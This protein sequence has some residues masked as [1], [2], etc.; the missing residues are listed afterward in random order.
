LLEM[1]VRGSACW[2]P[3]CGQATRTVSCFFGG[4]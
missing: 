3:Q 4:I 1:A 2:W